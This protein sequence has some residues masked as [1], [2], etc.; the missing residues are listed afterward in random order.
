MSDIFILDNGGYSLKCG[1]ASESAPKI[2]PNCVTKSKSERRRP[3]I[4]DQMDDCK[5]YSA[6][7]YILPFQKGFLINWDIQRQ[8]WDYL[9]K[10]KFALK[11]LS[12][13]NLVLTVPYFNFKSI[14]ENLIEI[15]LEEY[16]FK[17]LLLINPACLA[18]L[19]HKEEHPESLCVLVV[20]SGYSFTHI[21]PFVQGKRVKSKLLCRC[22]RK[23]ILLFV[24]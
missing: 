9:F 1:L 13:I 6:L 3:F 14:Q 11:N 24:S 10:T 17:S 4:G 5:E 15:F 22:L 18:A 16:G 2:V 21:V 19:K 7:F 12:D 20:D 8:I 23:L